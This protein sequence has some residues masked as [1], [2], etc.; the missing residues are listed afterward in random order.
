MNSIQL[1][2][3]RKMHFLHHV[4]EDDTAPTIVFVHG[5]PLDHSMWLEQLPL[6]QHASLLMLDLIGFG[7][8]DP[9]AERTTMKEMADD[10]ANLVSKLGIEKVIFC[11]LSMGGYIGWEFAS[12]HR[13]MLDGLICCNTR[14]AADDE[15]TARARG[16]A[17]SQVLQTGSD[18]VA[19]MMCQKLFSDA[20][21]SDR[22]G[23]VKKIGDVIRKTEPKAIAAGQLAMS[24]RQDFSSALIDIEVPTLVVSGSEDSITTPEEMAL[25]AME[26]P[27]VTSVTISDAG[28]LAPFE[29][30]TVFNHAVVHWLSAFSSS[31]E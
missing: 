29:Q 15:V 25:M 10:V 26:L 24:V 14:A 21:Q 5:F 11:G 22:P 8:S 9:I 7:E 28:H 19:T 13:E 23:L 12:N 31:A 6:Q 16:V 20:T 4:C 3:G 17:A 18:A 2:D 30:A 27:R 1:N